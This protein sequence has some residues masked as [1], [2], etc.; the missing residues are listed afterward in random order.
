MIRIEKLKKSYGE[1]TVIDELDLTIEDK[2]KVALMAPSGCGKTTLLRL[3]SGIEKPDGGR[4]AIDGKIAYVFQEPR[5]FP[6]FD[7]LMNVAAVLEGKDAK[8]RARTWL[9][10]AGLGG[11]LDKYP[12]ELSGGMAQRASLARALAA[13]RPILLLDEPFKGLDERAKGELYRL[14][15][16]ECREKTLI[17][18]THDAED[19]EALCTRILRFGSGMKPTDR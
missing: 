17:L 6:G 8:V 2:E 9:E 14:V 11:D 18:V 19:A 10:K 15:K 13:N 16:E 5:L 1:K 4:I 7:A 3:I 12:D